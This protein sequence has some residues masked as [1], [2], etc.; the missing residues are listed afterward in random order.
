MAALRLSLHYQWHKRRRNRTFNNFPLL[1]SFSCH[2]SF[3]A[4]TL[5]MGATGCSYRGEQSARRTLKPANPILICEGASRESIQMISPLLFCA[6]CKNPE[7]TPRQY[8]CTVSK[9]SSSVLPEHLKTELTGGTRPPL[10][11]QFDLAGLMVI[12]SLV[13]AALLKT[14]A[15]HWYNYSAVHE[16]WP[17][18]LCLRHRTISPSDY[19]APN[20]RRRRCV[21]RWSLN[22]CSDRRPMAMALFAVRKCCTWLK[23]YSG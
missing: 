3:T 11:V 1:T 17:A 19:P 22:L 14:P 16:C 23:S 12:S 5:K 21:L 10:H 2:Q 6:T 15:L 8:R 20:T 9:A 7:N 4:T 18:V 13:P